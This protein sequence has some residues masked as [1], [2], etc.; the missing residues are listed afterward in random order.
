MYDKHTVGYNPFV[1]K[2]ALAF[3]E[4]VMNSTKSGIGDGTLTAIVIPIH[5]LA[6]KKPFNVFVKNILGMM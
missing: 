6:S 4:Q 5:I 3:A 2:G 1:K